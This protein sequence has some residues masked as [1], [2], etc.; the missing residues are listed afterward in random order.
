[1]TLFELHTKM[2][3]LLAEINKQKEEAGRSEK[4]RLL[5]IA[6]TDL[7]KSTWAVGAIK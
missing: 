2:L 6:A 7:E 3:D 4:G 1:M 5:A